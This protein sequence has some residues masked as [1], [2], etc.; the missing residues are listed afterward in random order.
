MTNGAGEDMSVDATVFE[1]HEEAHPSDEVEGVDGTILL[2]AGN[3]RR[4]SLVDQKGRDLP[5]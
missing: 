1:E 4:R 5:G 3:R 2:V